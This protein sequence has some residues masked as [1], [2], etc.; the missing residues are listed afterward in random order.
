MK[1]FIEQV[2]SWVEAGFVSPDVW[3][4]L[5]LHIRSDILQRHFYTAS[6]ANKRENEGDDCELLYQCSY[7]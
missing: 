4:D 7:F 6:D 3:S 5:K 2:A 1:D